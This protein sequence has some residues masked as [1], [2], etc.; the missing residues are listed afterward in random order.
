LSQKEPRKKKTSRNLQAAERREQLLQ[1]AK[2]LFAEQ[3]YHA[4]STRSITQRIGMADG[5][6]YHYFPGG[7]LE[8]LKT[9]IREGHQKRMAQMD[10]V[11][12]SLSDDTP[13]RE[14]LLRFGRFLRQSLFTD[15]ELMLI[16]LNER[17]LL[18]AEEQ[19]FFANSIFERWTWVT[20]F[21]RKRAERGEMRQIDFHLAARQFVSIVVF[22]AVQVLMG[23]TEG[24]PDDLERDAE[25][26]I[27]FTVEQ[28]LEK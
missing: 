20:D 14:G 24:Q 1:A 11:R 6:I 28:W 5:L 17:G 3:G 18:D 9:I 7:K 26:L 12:F 19:H 16:H 2:S 25:R 13:L 10:E 15:R 22:S 21:L 8:M 23:L 4:T 27:A